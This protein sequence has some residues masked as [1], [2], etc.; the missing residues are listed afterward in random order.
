MLH[1]YGYLIVE[2]ISPNIENYAHV[3]SNFNFHSSRNPRRSLQ[4]DYT[5]EFFVDIWCFS[6][7]Y[8]R[9]VMICGISSIRLPVLGMLLRA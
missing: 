3:Q 5:T 1:V 4:E 8:K 2:C 9:G 6:T 7:N